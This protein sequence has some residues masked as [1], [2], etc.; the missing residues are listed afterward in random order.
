MQVVNNLRPMR[1]KPDDWVKAG[2]TLNAW[3]ET[4]PTWFLKKLWDLTMD[5]PDVDPGCFL[6]EAIH[7]EMNYRGEGS[8]VA[9]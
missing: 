9:L 8:Y 3:I 7:F 4:M 1:H 2:P 5:D 6:V